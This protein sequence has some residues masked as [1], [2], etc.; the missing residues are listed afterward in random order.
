MTPAESEHAAAAEHVRAR[1]EAFISALEEAGAPVARAQL[2]FTPASLEAL[3]ELLGEFHTSGV[4]A[5]Q[6]VITG[7]GCYVMEVGRAEHGGVYQAFNEDDPLVLVVRH[8]AG[9]VGLLATSKVKGRVMNG[10]EDNL[11]FFYAGFTQAIRDRRS[12]TIT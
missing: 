9:Q 4:E 1:A 11:P 5:P 3:D 8:E 10:P 12:A 7:A 6:D 2:D